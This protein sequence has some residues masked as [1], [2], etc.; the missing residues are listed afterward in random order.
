M[1]TF[2]K[3]LRS[4]FDDPQPQCAQVPVETVHPPTP[5]E[6]AAQPDGVTVVD[7]LRLVLGHL[8]TEERHR[9]QQRVLNNLRFG[10]TL[11]KAMV[12]AMLNEG[13]Q[14][15]GQ[16]AL[17][18]LGVDAV[19]D[20]ERQGRELA[21][22]AAIAAIYGWDWNEGRGR[23]TR[24]ALFALHAWLLGFGYSLLQMDTGGQEHCMLMTNTADAEAA[25][26]LGSA[27]GLRLTL[28]RSD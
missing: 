16:W 8:R 19:D 15:D 12:H 27:L 18:L 13:G 17:L 26:R 25:I 10:D 22:S 24:A 14:Q 28:P 3:R 1:L 11:P 23:S 6:P 2:L 7:W 5:A 20:V 21:R 9:L 4:R